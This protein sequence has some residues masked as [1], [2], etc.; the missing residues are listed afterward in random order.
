MN[1]R[2][3]FSCNERFSVELR[4]F[5]GFLRRPL[6]V[7]DAAL[8][9]SLTTQKRREVATAYATLAR[10]DDTTS[11]TASLMAPTASVTDVNT[12]DIS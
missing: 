3:S 7:D 6:I 9:L 5:G 2:R 12:T 1:H 11:T 4:R 8:L 10:P